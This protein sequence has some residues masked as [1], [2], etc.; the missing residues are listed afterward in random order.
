MCTLRSFLPRQSTSIA[1]PK[2]LPSLGKIWAIPWAW[3]SLW[4]VSTLPKTLSNPRETLMVWALLPCTAERGNPDSQPRN[5]HSAEIKALLQRKVWGSQSFNCALLFQKWKKTPKVVVGKWSQVRRMPGCCWPAQAPKPYI[6]EL[7][8]T[9]LITITHLSAHTGLGARVQSQSLR[10]PSSQ[11]AP[12][13][14]CQGCGSFGG[15][16][17]Q[18]S[19]KMPALG[20]LACLELSPQ[21]GW[22]VTVTWQ[23]TRPKFYS[24]KG[25]NLVPKFIHFFI[26]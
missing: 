26:C 21:W 3:T 18:I 8:I 10:T 13:C 11:P 9:L 12:L 7:L 6:S 15:R 22:R 20:I 2:F 4:S 19:Q 14:T 16:K 1:H 5:S 17:W 25:N 23:N 24:E